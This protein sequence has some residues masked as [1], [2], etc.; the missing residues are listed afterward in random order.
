MKDNNLMCCISVHATYPNTLLIWDVSAVV[1]VA[2]FVVDDEQH[3]PQEEAHG[4][5]GDVS[6]AQEGVLS[7]HPGDGAQD[8]PLPPLEATDRVVWDTLRKDP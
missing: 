1:A 4:A 5:H 3:H 6:D 7:P 8:H 2:I